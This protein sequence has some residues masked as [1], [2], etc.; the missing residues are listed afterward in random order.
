MDKMN[1]API[2]KIETKVRR[3]KSGGEM[4]VQLRIC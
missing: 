2:T 1:A 4:E 3:E